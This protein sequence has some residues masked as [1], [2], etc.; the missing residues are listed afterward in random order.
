MKSLRKLILSLLIATLAVILVLYVL[1]QTHWGAERLSDQINDATDWQVSIEGVDHRW[2]S[3]SH[4]V[5]T[6]VTFGHK[7]QPAILVAEQVDIGLSSR[8]ITQPSHVDSLLLQNGTL[9]L[10]SPAG[11]LPIKADSL[12]LAAMAIQGAGDQWRVDAA[13]VAGGIRPWLPTPQDILGNQAAIQLSAGQMTLNGIPASNVLVQ[14]EIRNGEVA[15]SSVGADVS[16]GSLSGN[17]LRHQDGSWLVNYL[18]VNDVRYQ[19]DK[20]LTAFLA[21]LTA[22]P[23]VTFNSVEIADSQ[24]QGPDWAVSDLSLSL[25]NLTLKGQDWQSA[26]GKLSISAGEAIYGTLHLFDPI[27]TADFG[28]SGV[29]LRQF[30]ARWAGGLVRTSGNWQRNDKRLALDDVAIAGLEY[31]LPGN[32]K[33]LWADPLPAWLQSLSVEKLSASRNL[34][35]DTDPAFP[36]QLTALDGDGRQ[37]QL[38]RNGQWGLWGGDLTLNAAAATFN[39]QDLR[40]PSIALNA[41]LSTIN[42]SELSAFAGQGMLEATATVSQLPQRLTQLSLT[43]RAVP[44]D[45][46][47]NWGWP[48][49]PLRGDGNMQLRLSGSLQQDRPLKPTV[50]GSLSATDAQGAQVQQTMVQGE[51][52]GA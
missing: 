48:T 20:P 47:H 10:T 39:R 1:I 49:L 33:R 8:Q 38:V 36:F 43:G 35:I 52:P 19:S 42:V 5:L 44:L 32:W 18:R 6:N 7:G 3:P 22:L 51:I 46:L 29:A 21:P 37:I 23:G 17:L 27:L 16:R 34:V 30:T 4:L 50:N 31:T 25:R 26:D 15:L 41:N 13:Q 2:S 11:N 12:Q 28:Q 45:T 9:N 40:R 14:G 24:L